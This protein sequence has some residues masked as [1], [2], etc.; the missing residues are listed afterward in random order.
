M[1]KEIEIKINYSP[2]PLQ[3]HIHKNFKRFNMLVLHRR[4]GKSQCGL[5]QMVSMGI[6]N[7]MKNPKYAF[8]APTF[9]QA[10]SISWDKLKDMTKTIPYRS[11]NEQDLRVDIERPWLGDKVS[12]SLLSGENY[13]SILG[14]YLDGVVFDEYQLINPIV[15]SRVVRPLLSDRLGFAMFLGTPRGEGHFKEMYDRTKNNPDWFVYVCGNKESKI[16]PDEEMASLTEN[17]SEEEV[18][19]E[20]ECSWQAPNSGSYYGRNIASLREKNQITQ[21]PHETSLVVDTAWDLGIDDSTT[22][23]FY[24]QN[25]NAVQIIDY[26]ENSGVGLDW[27][28]RELKQGHRAQYVYGRHFLPHDAA[29]R[30][31]GTGKTRQETLKGLGIANTEILK[32]QS[33]E[34]GIHASRML[35]PKCWIDAEKCHRGIL[36]IESYQKIWDEKNKIF[37]SKPKHDWSSHGADGFRTLAMGLRPTSLTTERN[38]L[39]RKADSDYDIFDYG[40]E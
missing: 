15:W 26:I 24:Q 2:R 27:Y 20:F 39:P 1:K 8:I 19:Q 36:A 4:F 18:A 9:R 40:R 33:L 25:G 37:S 16:I 28:A 35:L 14:I 7:K 3:E 13:E 21:V 29:A 5:A 12:F 31:L 22:I 30:D 6:A 38:N 23:W 17:M 11:T 32:R 34:D 10:K